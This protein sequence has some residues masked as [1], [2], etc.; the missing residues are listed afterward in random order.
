MNKI[1]IESLF[2][3]AKYDPEF[4]KDLL[5][6]REPALKESGI[7][8]TPGEL[9]LLSGIDRKKLEQTIDEFSVPGISKKSLPNWRAAA[10]V[11]MLLA[12]V[13]F[14]GPFCKSTG[15]PGQVE[16]KEMK[17]DGWVDENTFRVTAVGRAQQRYTNIIQRRESA[18][19]DAI[20]NAQ[21][22]IHDKFN[23]P[24]IRLEGAAAM[25]YY[26]I[27]GSFLSQECRGAI[28]GGAVIKER[29]DKDHNCEIV[30]EVKM[31]G[32][33]KKCGNGST[34]LTAARRSNE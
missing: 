23:P 25:A 21:S 26:E 6:N 1:N 30:Y 33:K 16:T 15:K 34:F 24:P 20:L 9:T 17:T 5:G 13:L 22:I 31:K 4:K 19:R 18:K 28:R 7:P 32:L 11:M 8:F 29:Y 3:M 10:A 27:T 14:A 2:L 12:S